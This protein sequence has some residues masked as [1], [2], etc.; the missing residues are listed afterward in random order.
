MEG[1]LNWGVQ[2]VLWFQQFSPTLDLPFKGITLLGEEDF[3]VIF[4]AFL[5]WCLDRQNGARLA[6]L[7]MFAVYVNTVAKELANQPRPF[8][9]DPRVKKLFDVSGGGFPSGHTQETVVIW[10]F[11][12]AQLRRRWLWVLAGVLMVLVPLSRIY[13]GLHFPTDLLGGYVIGGTLVVLFLWLEPPAEAWLA[14]KGV[15]WQIAA[16]IVVPLV[17][18]LLH[19]SA[20]ESLV[21]SVAILMGMGVG[22]ALERR[23][24]GFESGGPWMKQLL[25]LALG[26]T[27]VL[28]LR[29]GLKALFTGLEPE[30]ALRFLRY[31]ILGLWASVAAPWVFVK[32]GL[33][34][35]R[36]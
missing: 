19:P 27:V 4:M 34:A 18:I 36:A 2:V 20:D 5:Y 29:F 23:W 25:R 32:L 24:V 8:Q 30:V 22:I 1:V 21:S 13:L 26:L 7:L 3:F 17:L 12:A 15:A 10:G 28:I 14:K 31:V 9:Y 33:A 11:L 35:K 16:A 6:I